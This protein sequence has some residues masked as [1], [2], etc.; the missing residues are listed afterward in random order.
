VVAGETD[1]IAIFRDEASKG[2]VRVKTGESHA[3]WTL[4]TVE[5]REATLQRGAKTV[6]LMI[7]IP[8][9]P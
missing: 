4:R 5:G 3:G 1:G 2:V 8:S 9:A 6:I 7:A